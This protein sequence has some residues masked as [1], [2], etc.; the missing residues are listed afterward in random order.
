MAIGQTMPKG[1][2]ATSLSFPSSGSTRILG[3]KRVAVSP[4]PSPSGPH[5]PVRTLRK[6]RSIRFHMDDTICLLESLPQ[7]VLVITAP[8]SLVFPLKPVLVLDM[9]LIPICWNISGQ[10]PVQGEPQRP[11]AAPPCV[12]ASQRS[13]KH[14]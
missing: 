4:A 14:L 5:S 7:D 2:L 10:S 3:R 6:Q 1:S 8:N 9:L 13:S 11:E 12:E